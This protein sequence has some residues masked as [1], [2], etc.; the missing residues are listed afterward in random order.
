MTMRASG[1][2]I[3]PFTM[4]LR[5]HSISGTGRDLAFVV[6]ALREAERQAPS[7]EWR[8]I[9]KD[10]IRSF[11]DAAPIAD[12]E[13]RT[14]VFPKQAVAIVMESALLAARIIEIMNEEIDNAIARREED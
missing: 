10:T 13:T 2:T 8:T 9:V 4:S 11:A 1:N 6:P 5:D 7:D 12:D 3:G 14:V